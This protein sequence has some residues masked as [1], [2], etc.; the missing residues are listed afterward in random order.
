M[1]L[2]VLCWSQFFIGLEHLVISWAWN[3]CNLSR[4][5]LKSNSLTPGYDQE[6]QVQDDNKN[7]E[8]LQFLLSIEYTSTKRE[9]ICNSHYGNG[10]PAMFT[11]MC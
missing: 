1:Q 10:V 11:T 8:P 7:F 3:F 6:F 4:A 2:W 5:E 9:H